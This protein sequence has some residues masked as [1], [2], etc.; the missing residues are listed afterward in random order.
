[1]AMSNT[2]FAEQTP[3]ITPKTLLLQTP[4]H[5]TKSA[6]SNTPGNLLQRSGQ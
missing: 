5:K 4:G 6:V 2:H 3:L 1:M